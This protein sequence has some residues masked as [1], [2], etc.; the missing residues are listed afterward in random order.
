MA[1]QATLHM[2]THFGGTREL[3]ALAKILA[4]EQV[5]IEAIATVR[6]HGRMAMEMIVNVRQ[7]E[8]LGRLKKLLMYKSRELGFDM[9]FQKMEAYRKNKRLIVF[10][11]DST[12]VDMEIIDEIAK[13]AGV[14][15]E[16]ARVTEKA[17]RGDL[18]FEESLRQRVSLLK[19]VTQEALEQ[20]R[21]HIVLSKGVEELVRALKYLGYKIGVVTGG[22]DFFA[23]HLK[24]ML[25]YYACNRLEMKRQKMDCIG[26]ARILNDIACRENILPD[27]VVAVGDGS[28][29]AL[30]LGQAGLGI[31]YNAKKAL[32]DVA[33][34]SLGKERLTN[35]LIL[36]GITEEDLKVSLGC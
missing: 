10:D 21:Q 16:V 26:K 9:A 19:G 27:Q 15:R 4:A 13:L 11:M 1:C 31:A 32:A 30:M 35:I 25:V 36:L 24:E 5:N 17:M 8:N 14:Q 7:N 33:N 34:M 2:L 28:N 18:D 6:L 3:A 20:I 23:N 22:F 29:D 12:L